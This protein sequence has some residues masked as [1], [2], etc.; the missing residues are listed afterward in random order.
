M[1]K[2]GCNFVKNEISQKR[3]TNR[4]NTEA[5]VFPRSLIFKL[6]KEALKFNDNYVFWSWPKTDLEVN[7]LNLENRGLGKVSFSQ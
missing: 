6:Q 4:K 1:K 2:T 5:A 7:S 3:N